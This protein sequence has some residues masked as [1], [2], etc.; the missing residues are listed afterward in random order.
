MYQKLVIV[1][2]LGGDPE[3]RYTPQG[4]PVTNFSV[5]TSEKWTQDGEQRE[6]TTWFR[7]TAW[8]RLAETCAEYLTKGR[9]VL[10][11]GRMNPDPDTGGPRIWQGKDGDP[12]ASFE[13]TALTVKFLGNKSNSNGGERRATSMAQDDEIPF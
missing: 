1:G 12:R 2:N 6:R 10:V 4:T 11:E 13:V 5:A 9:Q 7:V 3:M 8:R